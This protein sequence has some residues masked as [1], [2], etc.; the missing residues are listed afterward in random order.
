MKIYKLDWSG[1]IEPFE[2]IEMTD[3]SVFYLDHEGKRSRVSTNSY[4]KYFKTIEEAIQ[5]KRNTIERGIEF[6]RQQILQ[7]EKE[8]EELKEF[9]LKIKQ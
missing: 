4:N 1:E 2:C 9:E 8:L 6:S 7:A 5:Y 3:K